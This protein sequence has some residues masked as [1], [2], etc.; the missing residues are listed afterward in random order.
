VRSA[1]LAIS[2]S[3]FGMTFAVGG[4]VGLVMDGVLLEVL[5]TSDKSAMQP[6]QPMNRLDLVQ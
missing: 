1:V 5:L 3:M 4:L 2:F 6:P